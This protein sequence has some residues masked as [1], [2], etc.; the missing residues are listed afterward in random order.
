MND[1]ATKTV[2]DLLETL[3]EMCQAMGSPLVPPSPEAFLR[4]APELIADKTLDA[5]DEDEEDAM[6]EEKE[7]GGKDGEKGAVGSGKWDI[8]TPQLELQ[9][10]LVRNH[11]V[12]EVPS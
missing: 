10:T 8:G 4:G 11:M 3:A 5:E 1:A 7:G 12:D 6:V 2:G 9:L